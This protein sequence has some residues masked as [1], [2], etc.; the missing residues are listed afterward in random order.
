MKK[1]FSFIL[2]MVSLVML[3]ACGSTALGEFPEVK[4][5]KKV[6]MTA[7]EVNTL[8]ADV[9]ME[10][11]M[12]QAMMLSIDLNVEVNEQINGFFSTEKL[13][14]SSLKL[15]MSSKTYVS[16]SD[17]ISEVSLISENS[18]DYMMNIDY[19][20]ETT[21]DTNE[22][23]KGK[24][25]AYFKDQY[26]YYDAEMT[27]LED[28]LLFDNG[29]FKMNLGI[30]QTMWDELFTTPGDL[31]GGLVSIDFDPMTLLESLEMMSFMV[32]SGMLNVYKSGSTY[33]LM[34]NINK[35]GIMDH[36]QEIFDAMKNSE[37]LTEADYLEFAAGIDEMLEQIEV[38]DLSMGIVIKDGSVQKFGIDSNIKMV[39]ELMN[40]DL[41]FKVVMDM[42]VKL[43]D[44]PKDL[45]E[46]KLTD[47]PLNFLN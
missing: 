37:E 7:E 21:T 32:D 41:T 11:Q 35:Q 36:K 15:V 39:D 25:N 6:E 31:I 2:I 27:G 9:D 12:K 19:V 3:N 38:L 43:P 14:D 8:L 33:T 30:T 4:E 20:K 23:I 29:K 16:L 26:L 1:I 10:T 42:G 34:I 18:V 45:D 22:N 28:N 5:N 24:L 40:F 47:L 44:F 17:Q 13:A 46:Y